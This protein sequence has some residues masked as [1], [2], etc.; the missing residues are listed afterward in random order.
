MG[1]LKCLVSLTRIVVFGNTLRAPPVY[2]YALPCVLGEMGNRLRELAIKSLRNTVAIFY[3]LVDLAIENIYHSCMEWPIK[4]GS[5]TGIR[6]TP[7]ACR[8]SSCFSDF[9]LGMC[10]CPQVWQV[11][12]WN[13]LN[14]WIFIDVHSTTVVDEALCKLH[15]RLGLHNSHV[16]VPRLH[17]PWGHRHRGR[18]TRKP[19]VSLWKKATANHLHHNHPKRSKPC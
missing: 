14:Y 13:W 2:T 19:A 12:S 4:T 1:I 6:Y 8:I 7:E 15:P 11:I 3:H 17:G 10:S 9:H 18:R 16:P 5:I